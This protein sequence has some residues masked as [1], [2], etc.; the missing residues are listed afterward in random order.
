MYYVVINR[1]KMILEAAVVISLAV[2]VYNYF[3]NASFKSKVTTDFTTLEAK[4]PSFVSA[5]KAVYVDLK[6]L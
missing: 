5:V 4:V 6:K 1:R 3:T 2:G